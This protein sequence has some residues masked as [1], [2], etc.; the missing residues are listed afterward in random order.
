[1]TTKTDSLRSAKIC[2]S[3]EEIALEFG[4]RIVE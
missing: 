2:R 1:M 3:V 4:Q